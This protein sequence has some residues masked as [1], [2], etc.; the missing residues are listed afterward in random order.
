MTPRPGG[1]TDKFG[2][3]YE[4]AWT[5]RHA[6][7]VLLGRGTSI[8]VEPSAP[9]GDGV[10][11]AYRQDGGTQVHQVKRQNRNANSWNVASLRGKDIWAGLRSHVDAGRA[12]HFVSLLPARPLDELAD[13]ARRS[14]DLVAF[15]AEWLTGELRGPFDALAAPDV[16]GSAATAW[17]MLR[18]LWVEWH[19]EQD[20]VNVNAVLAEQVLAGASGHLAAVGL[21]DLLLN[22]LGTT[23]DASAITARLERYGLRRV[24]RADGDAVADAVGGT[25]RKWA[26]SVERELLRP[27]IPREEADRLVEQITEGTRQLTLLT[28]AAGGGKSAVLHRA[29]SALAERGI[30]VLAFRLDRLLE[31]LGSTRELGR[32]VDLPM[33]PVGALGAVAGERPCVLIVDQLDAVSMASGRIPETFDAVADLL[34][35]AAAYPAM[36]VVFACR[37][38]DAEADPRVRRIATPER[39][40]RVEVGPLS[41]AQVDAAVASMGLDPGR[42]AQQQRV[43]LGAPLPL[44]LLGRVADQE[45]ALS[46][47]TTRQ[48]FDAFWDTKRKECVRRQ[49][50]VR[51]HEVVSAVVA[52]MSARQ[53]L[54]VPLSVLDA[55]DLAA[56][57][58]LLVSEHVCVRDGRQLA[59]FHESFFDYAFARDWLRRDESLVAFLVGGEQELFRRGQVR[60]VLDHLR[61]LDPERFTEEIEALLTSPDIRYHIKD[62]TLAVLR[63]LEAPTVGEWGAVVRVLNTRPPFRDQLVNAVSAGA[64][65]CRADDE[66]VLDDWLTS[67][68][69]RER[70]WAVRMMGAGAG[71]FPDRV[72]RLLESR[73]GDPQYGAWLAW[74]ARFARLAGSR[75]FLDL[76]LDG[77]RAGSFVGREHVLW[78]SAGDLPGEQ[79]VWA[80]ELISA[81]VAERP[82]ALQL[83][84]SGRVAALL[85]SDYWALRVVAAAALGAPEEFCA[86]GRHGGDCPPTTCGRF[87]LRRALHVPLL[88]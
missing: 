84:E 80:V 5:V 44:V 77:V 12:Y 67:A 34:S 41:D 58:E 66:A 81:L 38:F 29:F 26:A 56:S 59:F 24:S 61:D 86:A 2:N 36:R 1:E 70:D 4:G 57:G 82:D 14:D 52:A 13:R 40:T 85:S 49:P 76:L 23:L 69:E 88:R 20:I 22:N 79:P 16:Y 78:I 27:A 64:W 8:T 51:F 10:E 30:P 33:S 9:L 73:T 47:R 21:G 35:E 15:E 45:E 32:R 62:V 75:R 87:G 6:L 48:L 42:L 53:R 28:G 54:S 65:F 18:G 71:A 43:L 55:D 37:A 46:F 7:Y 74:V 50:S 72:A 68:D 25:T 31:P 83:D 39:C 17:R 3:R 60:Q 19:N 63:G 11:F